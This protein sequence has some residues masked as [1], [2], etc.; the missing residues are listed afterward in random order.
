MNQVKID[1]IKNTLALMERFE[2]WI[3][4]LY[5]ECSEYL[6]EDQDFWMAMANSE[7][8]HAESINRM[9]ELFSKNPDGYDIETPFKDIALVTAM[10]NRRE[11]IEKIRNKTLTKAQILQIAKEIELTIL[12]SR[13]NTFLRSREKEYTELVERIVKETR[14]H[15]KMLDNELVRQQALS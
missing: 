8:N 1:Q 15:L 12:E 11:D 4:R 5:K 13:Y 6:I 2:V 9:Y 10:D 7:I 3:A 14:E